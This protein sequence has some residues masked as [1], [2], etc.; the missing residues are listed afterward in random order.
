[1]DS[2]QD[3][4]IGA[5]EPATLPRPKATLYRWWT[6]TCPHC[7]ATL[8]AVE[9]LRETYEPKGLRVVG[10]Y[11]PKPPRRVD[12][13]SARDTARK[14]GYRGEVVTDEDWSALKRAYPSIGDARATSVTFLVDDKGIIRFF[15]PG[16]VF[17][18]SADA[19]FARENAD[20]HLLEQAVETLL[21]QEEPESKR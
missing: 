5:F 8:P 19:A 14:L 4:V 20:Y 9:R 2:E 16:P 7:R 12:A 15:H 1:M 18:P 17:F 10:V 11:H 21:R 3:L 6:D 13:E